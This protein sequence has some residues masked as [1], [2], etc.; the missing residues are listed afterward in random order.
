[1]SLPLSWHEE[2]KGK[3]RKGKERKGKERKGKERIRLSGH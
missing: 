3:E 2:R 1:M